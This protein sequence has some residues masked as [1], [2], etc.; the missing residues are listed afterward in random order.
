MDAQTARPLKAFGDT[1]RS[2]VPGVALSAA[3][4]VVSV[5]LEGPLGR[6][7]GALVGQAVTLPAM[8]IALLIGIALNPLARRPVFA[9]GMTFCVKK[10]LRVAVALLGIRI[11][12][13]DIYALGIGTAFVVIAS[14]ALTI[15][16]GVYIARWLGREEPYGA[17]AGSATAVCGASAALATSTVL[18]DYKNRNADTVF[19]VVAVNALSTVAMLAYPPLCLLL[20]FDAQKTGI[21]LGAT[22]HDVAQVVGAGYAVSDA[23]GDN[24]VIVKLFRVF[25]LLP[26]VLAVG[27]YFS[28]QGP[29]GRA[30]VPVPIFALVFLALAIVNSVGVVPPMVKA[31]MVDVS[32]WGLL[33][34]IGAL[35]LATSVEDIRRSGWRHLLVISLVTLVILAVVTLGL[36]TVV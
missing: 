26:V 23:V 5:L 18:P 13:G 25:L 31:G 29:T 10:L 28:A 9:P 8:V 1:L 6:V 36:V 19:I 11:A 3:L 17:L 4:A 12:L 16:S 27:W 30:N 32:R 14:M 35:G 33:I 21:L 2:L 15:V 22:I 20:G 7:L 24:A 34:A